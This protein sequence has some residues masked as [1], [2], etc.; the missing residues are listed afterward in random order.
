MKKA[1]AKTLVLIFIG[2]AI[3]VAAVLFGLHYYYSSHFLPNTVLCL[4]TAKTPVQVKL[5]NLTFAQ[6]KDKLAAYE[7]M[8][9]QTV[10]LYLD[11]QNFATSS[12][13]FLNLS[14]DISGTLM[15]L[16]DQNNLS[17]LFTH[18]FTP[19]NPALLCDHS[20]TPDLFYRQASLDEFVNNTATFFNQPVIPPTFTL[21]D[22]QE[23]EIATGTAG[24]VVDTKQTAANLLANAKLH[25]FDTALVTTAIPWQFTPEQL[26]TIS[27]LVN[28]PAIEPVLQITDNKVTAFAPATNGVMF[29]TAAFLNIA[30]M[31]G[32]FA[33]PTT[34]LY[35]QKS[36]AATNDLGIKELIG[37]GE[38]WYAH[39][40]PGRIHNVAL[41]ASK[42][43]DIL[44]APGEEFSF[45]RALGEVS[46]A[47]G[48]KP[49]YIIQG[50]RSVLSDGG[51]V[52]QVSSTLFRAL[53]DAG[54]KITRR[55]PH[56]Y[57][58]S[59]YEIGNKPG[60]DAT[61][62][63]GN[64]DLRFLNDTPGY[65]LLHTTSDSKNLYMTVALYGTSDGRTTE[66]INYKQYNARPAP[67]TEY[68]PDPSL[69]PGKRE[70][71]D[72]AASGISTSF[73]N[74]VRKADGT[75]LYDDTYVSNY[76]P[77]SAKFLVGVEQ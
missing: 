27:A 57:R 15:R 32:T 19:V 54:V 51:G 20:N 76:Q 2:L 28:T 48:Y 30:T 46:A 74:I 65:I 11:E 38:S 75:V 58:V 25:L 26:A 53:L 71:I 39:S 17:T 18:L 4:P 50:G 55:L 5:D 21:L 9:E 72:W 3:L 6:A 41:T 45:N 64:V 8:P 35:P 31:S 59:Y 62:Y 52:C 14:Y 33:I 56:S 12:A 61:V 40:I 37:F 16:L 36:L 60:F 29:D 69:P 23:I 66:I 42:I 73:Q 10:R 34:T 49:G 7:T 43:N 70:Q 24:L 44:I 67:A 68:I 1:R 77:W 47:T 22:N 13:A 63:S